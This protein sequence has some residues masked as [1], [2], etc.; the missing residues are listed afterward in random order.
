MIEDREGKGVE[1]TA[2]VTDRFLD[3]ARKRPELAGVFTNFSAQV[4]A[5]P[6]RH[7]PDQGP[8]PRCRRLRRLQRPPDQ[9]RGLLRQRLQPLRQDLEGHG[10]GRGPRPPP[11]RGHRPA[12]RPEPQG[13]QGAPERPGRGQVHARAD[14]R[15]A[16]Q[17]VHLRPD[18]RPARPG[19]QL[20]PGD[21]RDAGGGRRGPARRASA[22]SGPARPTRS[23]RPATSRPTS[24]PCRSSAS[25][26]SCRPST[27]AGSGRWSSS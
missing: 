12:V 19:L 22:T 26:C 10:P 7:R 18:H 8:P 27:R 4:P 5:A 13:R 16:L 14:R 24:S 20:G 25:S 17:H 6:V 1:A 15:A 23:R 2:S 9:P 3:A 21:R 11:A